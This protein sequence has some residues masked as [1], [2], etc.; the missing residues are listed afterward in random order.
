MSYRISRYLAKPLAQI[1]TEVLSGSVSGFMESFR[2]GWKAEL[3]REKAL[4]EMRRQRERERDE[5]L[6]VAHLVTLAYLVLLLRSMID[7]G[8]A[9]LYRSAASTCPARNNEHSG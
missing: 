3:R 2:Y 5:Q 8:V 7:P 9:A 1:G 6:T 4:D